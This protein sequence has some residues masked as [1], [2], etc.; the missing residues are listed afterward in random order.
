MFLKDK[1]NQAAASNA[2]TSSTQSP[3]T[4]F[5]LAKIIGKVTITTKTTGTLLLDGAVQG[6]IPADRL[7]TIENLEEGSHELE[8]QYENG[9]TEKIPVTIDSEEPLSIKFERVFLA[10]SNQAA[11]SAEAPAKIGSTETLRDGDPL[12]QASIKIDGDFGDWNG[13]LPAFLITELPESNIALSLAIDKVY[14]AVDGKNLYMRFD[15]KDVTMNSSIHPHNFF[16]DQNC[17]YCIDLTSGAYHVD[18][19]VTFDANRKIWFTSIG[20]SFN[21]QYLKD[22]E[23]AYINVAMKGFSMES[24]FPLEPIM[25]NLGP[26]YLSGYSS[27]VSARTGRYDDKWNWV[28]GSGNVTKEKQF[29]FPSSAQLAARL[30]GQAAPSVEAP[31]NSLSSATLRDGDP[32]P[33]ASIKIDGDFSDWNGI[34]PAFSHQGS[35]SH[36]NLAIDKVYLAVDTINLYMRLDIMDAT[37]SSF[38]HT[39]NFYMD[40]SSSYGLDLENGLNHV[41]TQVNFDNSLT[42]RRWYVEIGRIINGN[43]ETIDKKWTW[44]NY[45][46]KD[47]SLEASFPLKT[48]KQYLG[49]T[50]G[51]YHVSVR[52][53]YF[54]SRWIA[55]QGSGDTTEAKQFIF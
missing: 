18:A 44:G 8:M 54:D 53:F 38:F 55:V 25:E 50:L 47:S 32:L 36:Q 45:A 23:K 1:G 49:S 14:L 30:Q 13:I 27:K 42:V 22:I 51:C 28:N 41:V 4:T 19:K 9:Q 46:M 29:T 2:A 24:S 34:L 26:L 7:A 39:H 20:L 21:G 35:A 10:A 17:T 43:W 16:M 40:D 37:P 48:I 12:P 6:Q 52:T 3:K 31:Q 15:I 11:T 33:L 5:K